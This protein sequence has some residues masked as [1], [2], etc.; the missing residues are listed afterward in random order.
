MS[1]LAY[2]T[3]DVDIPDDDEMRLPKQTVTAS[4][5]RSVSIGVGSILSV[6]N[7]GSYSDLDSLE[8]TGDAY[9]YALAC[10]RNPDSISC[11]LLACEVAPKS[12]E[13]EYRLDPVIV[14]GERPDNSN[15]TTDLALNV[16]FSF[17][18]VV[19]IS[20]SLDR[21][22]NEWK[23]RKLEIECKSSLKELFARKN[24]FNLKSI[25]PTKPSGPSEQTHLNSVLNTIIKETE[26][27]MTTGVENKPPID[28]KNGLEAATVFYTHKETGLFTRGNVNYGKNEGR[29]VQN[30][31]NDVQWKEVLINS[32]E[33]AQDIVVG[34][35][36]HPTALPSF[37]QSVVYY[38]WPS[39]SDFHRHLQY[40]LNGEIHQQALLAIGF[41]A[42][43][44]YYV[45]LVQFN[46]EL[47]LSQLLSHFEDAKFFSTVLNR[48]LEAGTKIAILDSNGKDI[49]YFKFFN[50]KKQAFFRGENVLPKSC[51][52]CF[53]GDSN[54]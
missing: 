5:G 43:V 30:F 27:I 50:N 53:I 7:G 35:H 18:W 26:P 12:K 31:R 48:L 39:P 29:V 33:K 23:R 13:C 16:K 41:L 14:T 40:K 45:N 52:S 49:D 38:A 34:F 9:T 36:T 54:E 20:R 47:S 32:S 2:G 19:N 42:N 10:R 37:S 46:K 44:K 21:A 24:D 17:Q 6:V 15:T 8:L 4:R 22:K 51:L 28:H 25:F 1:L 3:E 11:R